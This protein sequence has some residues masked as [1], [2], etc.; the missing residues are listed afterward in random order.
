M[1][2]RVSDYI[3]KA[4]ERAG[5][6]TSFSVTGGFAMHLN[7][8]FGKSSFTNYYQHHEQA[9][10]YA[11][12]GYSRINNK[13][14]V[15]STTAGVGATNAISPCLD[16]YQDSIPVL[17]ISGQV[18]TF[19]TI[20]DIN[21][22][23]EHKLRNYAFSDCDIISMVSSVTKYCHE[24]MSVDEVKSVV[25]TAIINL[26]TGRLGPVWLSVPLDIQGF[27]IDDDMPELNVNPA[28]PTIVLDSL[29]EMLR[30]SKRPI[31]LAGNGINLG[32]CREKFMKFVD[33]VRI[34]VTTTSLG[35]DVIESD[36][37][38]F[39]GRS[40]LYADRCGNFA[41][42]NSDLL[43]VLGCRLSQAIVGYNPK[44]FARESKIVYV[45]IDPNELM[46]QTAPYSLTILADL[47][48]FFDSFSS[49][50]PSYSWWVEKCAHWK[51]K[52]L[53]EIPT[54]SLET[55]V[56]NPYYAVNRLMD[57]LPDNKVV[58]TAAGTISI[59]VTQ[60]LNVK[61]N[62]RF[63]VCGQYDMGPDLPMSIGAYIA[64]PTKQVVLFTGDGT[65]QFNIQELQTIVHHKLP[66]K[67]IVF[68]NSGYAAIEITQ[69][70]F[71]KAKFGVDVG[72]GLS[73]PD[74]SKIANAYGIKYISVRENDDLDRAIDEFVNHEGSVIF[75]I[76]C[77]IQ[78]RYPKLSAVKNADGTFTSRPFEDMEPFMSRE[79]FFSE[80]IVKPI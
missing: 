51:K 31:I 55:Q 56:I 18:K 68:N 54:N 22:K 27:L 75:E 3:V 6:N 20:R 7:D 47:N 2:I 35:A 16:A 72:S 40:G 21:S 37:P 58:T 57:K 13:P 4:L 74:T 52:W 42:Q 24:I 1:K 29:Y 11:A 50:L 23:T 14:S 15:V 17:F 62:D 25:D 70:T 5:I 8:S 10:G 63:L 67:T 46:K 41:I 65:F 64:D 66:V 44:T 71:F 48:T 80:M 28:K 69:R 33:Q 38:Y 60:L 12:I 9:C 26:T 79:E 78:P 19:D 32:N 76:F 49:E 77:C 61:K 34:P 45:D 73:F 43:L 39:V 53:F 30:A 59:I 36:S